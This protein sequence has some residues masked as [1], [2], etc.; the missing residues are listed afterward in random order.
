M[1][2]GVDEAGGQSQTGGVHH[3]PITLGGNDADLR[4]HGAVDEHVGMEGLAAG[5]VI[6][7]GIPDQSF[8]Q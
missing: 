4:D 3:L 7:G 6:D 2:V 8:F 5:A 1:A